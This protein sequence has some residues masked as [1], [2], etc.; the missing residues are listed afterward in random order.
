MTGISALPAALQQRLQGELKAGEKLVWVGQPDPGRYMRSGFLIW[1]FFIPWT[2]FAAFWI[3]GAAGFEWPRF[4]SGWNWFPLFGLPFLLIG[5][6]GLGTPFWMRRKAHSI[7]YA[8]TNQ[9]ALTLEGARSV[10]V[11]NY[12][13]G[14]ILDLQRTEHPDGTGNLILRKEAYRDSDGD[15]Q[16]RQEGFMAIS[17]VRRVEQ[18]IEQLLQRPRA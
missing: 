16:T 2:A 9:R 17:E 18:L 3:C 4:D 7:I 15:R 5:L 6:G 12:L 8:I 11:K 13:P 10:T 14:T 1:L